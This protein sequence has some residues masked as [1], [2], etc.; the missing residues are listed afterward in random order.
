M[1]GK[2]I[3]NIRKRQNIF[4]IDTKKLLINYQVDQTLSVVRYLT[5]NLITCHMKKTEVYFSKPI[6]GGQAILDLSKTLMYDFHHNYIRKNMGIKLN[7]YLR[8]LI[9]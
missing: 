9:A 6:Y 7:Y 8:I 4:L 3:E 1:F 5:K 2:A